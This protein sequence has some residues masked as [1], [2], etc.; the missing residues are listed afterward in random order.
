MHWGK[1][2][3]PQ[4]APCFDGSVEYPQTWCHFGCAVKQL[5]PTDKFA[6]ASNVWSWRATRGG[7]DVPL[8]QCCSPDTG[9]DYQACQCAPRAPCE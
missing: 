8:E 6:S 3:W 4:H 2:G 9:F 5:D 7:A 1:A